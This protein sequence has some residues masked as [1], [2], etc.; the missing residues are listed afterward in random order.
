M[1]F[2]ISYGL[3]VLAAVAGSPRWLRV[4]QR[5]HYLA[6]SV[7]RFAARWYRST[8]ANAALFAAGFIAAVVSARVSVTIVVTAAVVAL[9]PLGLSLSGRTSPLAWTR[10]MRTVAVVAAVLAA[11][12]W[13]GTVLGAGH[14]IGL[15]VAGVVAMGLP[16]VVDAAL[17]VTGPWEKFLARRYVA[18]ATEKLRRVKP[19]V[20]AITGSYGKT[21]TKNYVAHLLG[22][23]FSVVASP[24]S[25]NNMAG[26]SRAVNEKLSLG[27]DVFIAE[28]G[29]YG[30]G[31]I[32]A[33]CGWMVPEVAVITAIGPVHLERMKSEENI[34]ACKREI[35]SA[36]GAVVLNTDDPRLADLA[37]ELEAEGRVV[38]RAG[39]GSLPDVSL[40]EGVSAT[41]AACAVEVARLFGVEEAQI[42]SRLET[43]PTVPNRRTSYL[44][45]AGFTVVDDTYNSN[46]A[47]CRAALALLDASGTPGGGKVVVTPGMVELGSR[48]FG[49]N[50]AF[51]AEAVGAG[52]RLV[53]VGRTN[54]AALLA[55]AAG[56]E[57][58]TVATREDAVAWVRANMGEGDAVLYENDL[59]D[60]FP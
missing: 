49:E 55:G 12:G 13:A 41:N 44:S 32:A 34:L 9:A 40:P 47:G 18:A 16:L 14:W 23:R 31:E 19:R 45:E 26:L 46:P 5:E 15:M 33:L 20:V 57:V 10:R 27:T 17:F 2:W 36:A 3:V 11:A 39:A 4:A 6:G 28:M 48:Q 53:V 37:G 58:V 30:P 50:A 60:H 24:A 35:T 56:T 22:A 7:T 51:A 38:R 1:S 21:S 25:F 8:P 59:P 42:A 52:Y 29:T 54:R 43:L